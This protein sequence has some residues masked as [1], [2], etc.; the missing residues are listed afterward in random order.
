MGAQS[1]FPLGEESGRRS[2]GVV[3]HLITMLV[4]FGLGCAMIYAAGGQPLAVIL[5][6]DN[7]VTIRQPSRNFMQPVQE[8][9]RAVLSGLAVLPFLAT[10]EQAR[11]DKDR[12]IDELLTRSKDNL[13]KN[14][15]D[16][17]NT[18][19]WNGRRYSVNPKLKPVASTPKVDV[20]AKVASDFKVLDIAN[21]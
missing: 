19:K 9:R 18:Q 7:M 12:Y 8:G 14:N 5:P 11:A 3:Q 16:R 20:L 10:A 1:Y 13:A 2:A 6:A 15:A 21:R 4:G 17:L